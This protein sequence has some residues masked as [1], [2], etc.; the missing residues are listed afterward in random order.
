VKK[1]TFFLS[2]ENFLQQNKW[3]MRTIAYFICFVEENC[4]IK[5]GY[6]FMKIH[7]K[8]RW[9]WRLKML[10]FNLKN[11]WYVRKSLA[12]VAPSTLRLKLKF[13]LTKTICRPHNL[14]TKLRHILFLALFKKRRFRLFQSNVSTFP[15]MFVLFQDMPIWLILILQRGCKRMHWPAACRGRSRIWHLRCFCVPWTKWVSG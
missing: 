12:I 5:C 10:L 14:S 6:W 4:I 13:R 15:Y 1:R 3:N 11:V 8:I 7:K 9:L 2:S